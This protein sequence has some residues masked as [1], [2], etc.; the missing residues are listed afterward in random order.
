MT[1]KKTTTNK[2]VIEETKPETIP[3]DQEPQPEV[4]E[5]QI[6]EK[7]IENQVEP[8]TK[9]KIE[10]VTE[11]EKV[12]KQVASTTTTS[13]PTPT[14]AVE[15]PASKPK[16]LTLSSLH[17]ELIELQQK[18]SEQSA[19]IAQLLEG[20]VRQRKP[21][22]SND[23]KQVKDTVTG[24]IYKSQNAAYKALLVSGEL[25]ELIAKGVFGPNPEKNGWGCYQMFR[26]M[27]GRFEEIHAEVKDAP[28]E[29][30]Q[31]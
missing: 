7:T 5:I 9:S 12:E 14:P 28:A 16:P 26:S 19:L 31:K 23:R 10:P 17:A 15:T 29:I 3:V 22:T 8:Q 18:F 24:V 25:K 20:P 2:S 6:E 1:K 21:V 30:P 13:E 4:P 11:P 27:P